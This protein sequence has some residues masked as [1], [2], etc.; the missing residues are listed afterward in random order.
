MTTANARRQA[1]LSLLIVAGAAFLVFF[2]SHIRA[3]ISDEYL[4]EPVELFPSMSPAGIDF[5]E[6]VYDPATAWL[7]GQSPYTI[8][9]MWYPPF[10]VPF[11]LP[12]QLLDVNR[13]YI[14]QVG[15][16]FVLNILAVAMAV[17]IAK[18][19]FGEGTPQSSAIALSTFLVLAFLQVSSY[20]FL[21]SIERG[22]FDIYPQVAALLGLWSMLRKPSWMWLHVACFSVAV[23]LKIY[24]AILFLLVLWKHGWKSLLP[25]AVINGFL[26]VSLGWENAAAFLNVATQILTAPTYWVGNH[27]AASFAFLVNGWL[28]EQ[29]GSPIQ[30]LVFFLPPLLIWVLGA[31]SLFRR[32][33]SSAGAVWFYSLSVPLMNLLPGTS[34]DYKLVLLGAPLAMVVYFLCAP[35]RDPEGRV[36]WLQLLALMASATAFSVSLA[37]L[38]PVLSNKYLWVCAFEVVVLWILLTSQH[39]EGPLPGPEVATRIEPIRP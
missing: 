36:H 18:V 16:L 26:L 27:S 1:A 17:R 32:G 33:Y 11:F 9:S 14:A 20:G 5:R 12:F 28:V 8:P 35:P 10:S 34:H 29:A 39:A 25:I 6:G 24:P 37:G 21:F 4:W 2:A 38:H 3:R 15:L 23:H 7:R 13:A 19:A 30:A 22:N 31:I